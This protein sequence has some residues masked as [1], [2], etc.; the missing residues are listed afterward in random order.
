MRCGYHER[1]ECR[2]CTLMGTP[3]RA[4]LAAKEHRVRALVDRPGLAWLPA[5]AGPE[6]GFRNKAK[7]VVGGTVAAPT[8]GILDPDRHGVDLRECGILDPA[9][10]AAL[11]ALAR[12]V[13][14][15]GLVPY[16]VNA[17]RG[18][19]KHVITTAAPDGE[20]M[21]RFVLRSTESLPRVR[22]HLPALLAEVPR[23]RVA[24]ANLLPAHAAVLEGEEEI[25]LTEATELRMPV[26]GIA[27]RLPPRAFF[28]TN[29]A[30]AAALYRQ[31]RAWAD[32]ALRPEP[33]DR[34]HRIWDLYCGIGGFALSLAEP[35]REVV[36]IETG[37]EAIR[38]ATRA[39]AEAGIRATT[40]LAADATR[41]AREQSA[42]PD[43]VVVNPPRR[44]LG[45]ELADWIEASGV[46][47]VVYSS[48]NP[49]T[50]ARDLARMPSL[51]PR[52]AR[53]FDMFPQTEHLEVMVLLER[54]QEFPDI[55]AAAG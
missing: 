39:A 14:R 37:A 40:F 38:A 54:R 10:V 28:Q 32:R 25:A 21:T 45:D 30:I 2:S 49:D 31:A 6:D 13:T 35:G 4:Q 8:L 24:T 19:L 55:A 36:G 16:D 50:L 43:L 18:E 22:K 41:W 34:A 5:V 46:P 44:G 17:R 3:H 15:A 26:A 29:T 33:A 12:F 11:P 53:V 9:I 1:G 20:L 23:L 51:R 7:M 42:A 47:S 27:L 52:E 48:C